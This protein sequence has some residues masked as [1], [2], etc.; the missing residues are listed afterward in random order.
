MK[1][2][3]LE[4]VWKGI[5][6]NL[7]RD[8]EVSITLRGKAIE[9]QA[10]EAKLGWVNWA[11]AQEDRLSAART[12]DALASSV[13]VLSLQDKNY[14][15]LMSQ[16]NKIQSNFNELILRESGRKRSKRDKER[17]QG[18]EIGWSRICLDKNKKWTNGGIWSDG[19]WCE[20]YREWISEGSGISI[21]GLGKV[22]GGTGTS[23]G[24]RL[25]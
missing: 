15:L 12:S 11:E 22:F 4:I 17:T 5:R 10:W 18:E 24:W 23:A 3:R 8:K 14:R 7:E 20:W 21:N 13:R 9:R 19:G 6:G 1:I 2:K 25:D 16:F